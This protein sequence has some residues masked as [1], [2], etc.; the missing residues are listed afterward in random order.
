MLTEAVA[1][2]L[3]DDAT[4]TCPVYYGH[5]P[6]S[7]TTRPVIVVEPNDSYD[8]GNTAKLPVPQKL[9][10]FCIRVIGKKQSDLSGIR[11]A[12]IAKCEVIAN[13]TT[14]T[15]IGAYRCQAILLQDI[16]SGSVLYDKR[17][18]DRKQPGSPE[19]EFEYADIHF[20]ASYHKD[21]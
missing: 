20:M 1:K 5:I 21:T 19:Q 13:S 8:H 7:V 10:H 18:D 9:I 14:P 2:W 4:I 11:D 6:Q 12:I 15:T 16:V 3:D 17:V